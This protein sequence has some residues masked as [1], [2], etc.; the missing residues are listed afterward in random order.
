MLYSQHVQLG[1]SQILLM[2]LRYKPCIKCNP[3]TIELKFTRL[4][5]FLSYLQIYKNVIVGCLEFFIYTGSYYECER[6]RLLHV[7]T[8]FYSSSFKKT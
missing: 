6:W 7:V 4:V 8:K 2:L 5:I 3:K 1:Q